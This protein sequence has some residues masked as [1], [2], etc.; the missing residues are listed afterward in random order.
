M[1]S[2]LVAGANVTPSCS[3]S[4]PPF[5]WTAGGFC[6]RRLS[7][8]AGGGRRDRRASA[9]GSRF[10]VLGLYSSP[11]PVFIAVFVF[12]AAQ[13]EAGDVA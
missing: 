1:A 12:L 10:S 5:Q 13:S 2:R 8:S 6:A 11:D 9:R 3:I 4:S 7:A